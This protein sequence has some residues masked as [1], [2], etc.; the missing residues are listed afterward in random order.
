MRRCRPGR[1]VDVEIVT[2]PRRTRQTVIKLAIVAGRA[3][4]LGHVFVGRKARPLR[5]GADQH[6]GIAVML[7]QIHGQK[8]QMDERRGRHRP[9]QPGNKTLHV[10]VPARDGRSLRWGQRKSVPRRGR[11]GDGQEVGSVLLSISSPC[12][13]A[14]LQG[15]S[16]CSGF[17]CCAW[18][19]GG[20]ETLSKKPHAKAQRTQRMKRKIKPA[21]SRVVFLCVLCAFA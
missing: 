2:A 1:N 13:R 3:D 18:M 20:L 5:A 21:F 8:Q 9:P 16:D 15:F 4:R 12:R 6:G 10:R 7:G 17:V 11:A 19:R 14:K